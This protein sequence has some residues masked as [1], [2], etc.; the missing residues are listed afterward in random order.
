[1]AYAKTILDN[2][3]HYFNEYNYYGTDQKKAIANWGSGNYYATG[4]PD[5]KTALFFVYKDIQNGKP[6]VLQVNGRG[7]SQHFVTVIGFE[8]VTSFDTLSESNFLIIDPV[9]FGLGY[10]AEN[11][12]A[13]GYSVK[14]YEDGSPNHYSMARANTS[15][16]TTTFSSSTPISA[17]LKFDNQGHGNE[18]N[19]IT[20]T[21]GTVVTMPALEDTDGMTFMWWEDSQ[22]IQY[23]AG[24][25]YTVNA[26]NTLYAVW[27]KMNAL[28]IYA[29]DGDFVY[30][31][32]NPWEF[33][34]ELSS[35]DYR[36]MDNAYFYG[37][38]LS[39][40]LDTFD[41]YPGDQ[42]YVKGDVSLYPLYST[43]AQIT[44][45]NPTLIYNINEVDTTGYS[46]TKTTVY[47]ERELVTEQ[48][49]DWSEW[50]TSAVTESDTRIVEKTTLYR[51][52][53]FDCPS[54]DLREPYSGYC[55]KGHYI[56]NASR[57]RY[58]WSPIPYSSSN[59]SS[60]DGTKR[61]TTS[62]GDGMVWYFDNADINKTAIGSKEAT[63]GTIIMQGYRY[64]DLVQDVSTVNV[65]YPAYILTPLNS[66]TISYN[67]NGG[68]G[69][70][71]AQTYTVEKSITVNLSSVKPTR[72]GYTFLGWSLLAN[73]VTPDYAAGALYTL[74][75]DVAFYAI[76]ACDHTH[77]EIRNS[78]AATC[79]VEGYTGDTYCTE[80]GKLISYGTA[81]T[82]IPHTV[83]TDKAVAATCSVSGKTEGSHCSVCH[84]VIVPQTTVPATGKHTWD[85]GTVTKPA[86]HDAEGIMTYKCTVC[87]TTRTESIPKLGDTM[88]ASVGNAFSHCGEEFK[89]TVHIDGIDG[90]H[91]F[92]IW[93]EYDRNAF[94]FVG[95]VSL[96][97]NT[98]IFEASDEN[99]V[100]AAF[101]DVKPV[102]DVAELT[103]RVK[104]KAGKG[105]YEFIYECVAGDSEYKIHTV[106]TS[107]NVSVASYVRGDVNG[108]GS[109]NSADAIYLLRHTMRASKYPINQ[110]GD[111]NGDGDTN[112]ADA[113]YL[114]RYTMRPSKYPLAD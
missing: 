66:Y 79:T 42:V 93:T 33:T 49:S 55:D 105:D 44:S 50:S 8:N 11:L 15:A 2:K 51:Y 106:T 91:S 57:F 25:P 45:G 28:R 107:G 30:L 109:T 6:V 101:D 34:Y 103:F 71:S 13:V 97:P 4:Y 87:S 95:A 65:G 110:S 113:I 61:K 31:N 63:G 39:P 38:S 7:S 64:S 41:Y 77:E 85:K 20:V 32:I 17:T 27:Y 68:S 88:S 62:L 86:S 16:G 26:N 53:Y 75:R 10:K 47:V 74:R 102:G 24:D 69:A 70:P 1:M 14:Y 83:V 89:V 80:C 78:R 82:K 94:E 96:I 23:C 114:L 81:L 90:I 98:I 48:W 36:T 76:W 46:V 19:S 72:T 21:P 22:G 54:C 43:R 12:G 111:V 56:D 100:I 84:T 52:Y 67:A 35:A 59:S 9:N 3:V 104:D 60:Y 18:V 40:D 5:K 29:P 92:G 73:D 58:V 108:D 112:S 99:G 37:W